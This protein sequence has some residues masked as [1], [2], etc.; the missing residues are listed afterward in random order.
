MSNFHSCVVSGSK[1]ITVPYFF[2]LH[3]NLLNPYTA[4][5]FVSKSMN[6]N[7]INIHI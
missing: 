3:F 4:E 6:K 5:L 1:K 2:Y 7:P